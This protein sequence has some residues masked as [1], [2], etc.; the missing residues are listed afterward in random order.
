MKLSNNSEKFRDALKDAVSSYQ[1]KPIIKEEGIVESVEEGIAYISGLENAM[2]Y[3]V[4]KFNNEIKGI[5]IDIKEN[6][7]TAII[8]EKDNDV[9]LNTPVYR[10]GYIISVPV[11]EDLLG[12]VIDPLGKPLDG[13]EPIKT[14]SFYPVERDA[15]QLF[16]RDFVKDQLYTGIKVID[17]MFPIGKGQRELIL[18]DP[19]TGKTSIA[20]DTILNQ[21]DK[22]VICIY[23]SIGQR[24]Q[25]VLDVYTTLKKHGSMDYTVIISATSDQF[26]GLQF[27]APYSA[28]AVG[29]YFL[30]KSKDVLIIYDD[31]T[32]HAFSY[33]SLSLLLKRPPGR[34]AFPGDIFYIHS[35]LLERACKIKNG[36]SI[37]A[38]PIVETQ[39]GRISSYIPTNV[40]S[41]TDGQ[42]YLDSNLFNINQRPAVDVGKSVSRI[43]GK[44][45]IPA[46][47]EVAEFL[48]LYYA[49]FLEVEIFTKLG[50]KV[51]GKTAEIIRR[52]KRLRELL[53]QP[54][55]KH[56]QVE[57]QVVIFFLLNE[58]FFDYIPVDQVNDRADF[59]LEKIKEEDSEILIEIKNSKIL[60]EEIKNR[61]KKLAEKR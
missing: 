45:Q 23:V 17:S 50:V 42:I 44:T 30:D 3:E 53:K 11:S 61:I 21:K 10:T 2:F 51:F 18:G 9:Q 19:S 27:I 56:Y 36:G 48:R 46:L 57:E 20:V 41:I 4:L 6:I 40:I 25:S 5:V 52:G 34:E 38:L 59:I 55:Y 33:Q 16:D 15:P 39:A 8:L 47:K 43:G 54:R 7:T 22:N 58:G 1:L 32:K 28:T 29:E 26:P 35:R 14:K 37:T 60:T 49:Q 13:L 31:L 12:R 24:K